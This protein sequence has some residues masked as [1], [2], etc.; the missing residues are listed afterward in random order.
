M[1]S[2]DA[3]LRATTHRRIGPPAREA[4]C[5][6]EWRSPITAS[7]STSGV[8]QAIKTEIHPDGR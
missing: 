4:V 7:A 2:S 3:G 6:F 1:N 8:R 5:E